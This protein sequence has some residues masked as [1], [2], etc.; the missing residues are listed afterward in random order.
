MEDSAPHI[1][2]NE[3]TEPNISQRSHTK[4]QASAT[5]VF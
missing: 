5:A 1:P 2:N 4:A 3:W